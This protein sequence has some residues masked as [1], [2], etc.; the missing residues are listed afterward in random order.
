M[1]FVFTGG[2]SAL[3]LGVLCRARCRNVVRI[4]GRPCKI[5]GGRDANSYTRTGAPIVEG[6]FHTPDQTR[7]WGILDVAAHILVGRRLTCSCL[8]AVASKDSRIKP[9]GFHIDRAGSRN[10]TGESDM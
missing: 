10:F 2:S 8:I 7:S 4:E 6:L 1:L 5:R 3:C 9:A